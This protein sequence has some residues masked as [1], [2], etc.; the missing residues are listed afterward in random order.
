MAGGSSSTVGESGPRQTVDGRS[1]L[2]ERASTASARSALATLFSQSVT[3]RSQ[4]VAG[5]APSGPPAAEA[6]APAPA[7]P[8][9]PPVALPPDALDGFVAAVLGPDDHAAVEVVRRLVRTGVPLDTVYM[10]LLAPA[11]VRLGELWDADDCD[12]VAVTVALG[13]MQ[14]V[15]RD[16]SHVF[17]ANTARPDA[18]GAVL[19]T[20]VSGE[21]HTLG[22]VMIAD[23]LVR[24]GWRVLVGAPWSDADLRTLVRSEHFDVVGFSVAC[25]SRIAA[26]KRQVQTLRSASRN[27][28]M[29]VLVG[30]QAFVGRP[31]LVT[32]VGADAFAE[33]VRDIVPVA[34]Q[35]IGARG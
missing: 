11:A 6:H 5:Q 34:R 22:I 23:S 32:R 31:D 7:E 35:L 21:Q 9:R 10:E 13:R 16:V 28:A 24:D 19:L 8:T 26:V 29:K 1:G 17:V 27:P 14:R 18:V 33:T 25:E 15:L 2:G 4:T 12:F 20:C 30:G 3:T